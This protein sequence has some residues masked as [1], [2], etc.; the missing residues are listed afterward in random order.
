MA[1]TRA[2]SGD[3]YGSGTL[4]SRQFLRGRLPLLSPAYG[5]L[6]NGA[7]QIKIQQHNYERTFANSILRASP[8]SVDTC[9]LLENKNDAS[10]TLIITLQR[11][12]NSLVQRSV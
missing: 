11:S 4:H 1:R 2:Q 12:S 5:D 3:R 9:N 8:T 10:T 7:F 6:K